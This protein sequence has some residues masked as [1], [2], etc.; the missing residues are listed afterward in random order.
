[1][2]SSYYQS[3]QQANTQVDLYQL[4]KIQSDTSTPL[5][6]PIIADNWLQDEAYL[7]LQTNEYK[8]DFQ[9]PLTVY[10]SNDTAEG[11][12]QMK[13]PPNFEHQYAFALELEKVLKNKSALKVVDGR[14][15][16]IPV[17]ESYD[18]KSWFLTTLRD[19]KKLIE[20]D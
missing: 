18:E 6:F 17:F 5:L 11:S 9:S 7:L 16:Q 3:R 15:E 10:W 13:D 14:G 2:R 4:R 8:E 20:A 1:M 19:F 12:I